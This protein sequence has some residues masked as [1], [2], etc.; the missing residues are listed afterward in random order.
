MFEDT[1][2]IVED[3]R[4]KVDNI[5][6][7]NYEEIA[8]EN[9]DSVL[10]EV[11]QS[12][13]VDF[14]TKAAIATRE[15][16]YPP[17]LNRLIEN[18]SNPDHVVVENGKVIKFFD[19]DVAG[20][21][22]DFYSGVEET[23]GHTGT[24]QAP[25]IWRYGIY[26]PSSFWRGKT[27]SRIYKNLPSYDD[28]ISERLDAWGDKAPFWYLIEHGNAGGGREFPSIRPT[29]FLKNLARAVQKVSV[30][31]W[32]VINQLVNDFVDFESD[33][34]NVGEQKRGTT[35]A[36]ERVEIPSIGVK[37]TKLRSSKG[38]TFYNLNGERS[39]T[40]AEVM[41]RIRAL[42]GN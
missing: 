9:V 19:E 8:Q 21:A 18:L 42:T 27:G 13:L 6:S 20:T 37:L 28:V 16:A 17:L 36:V 14:G 35:I 29:N 10:R 39:L 32:D 25:A 33:I 3:I 12:M 34:I 1:L 31:T 2:K 30:G 15:Y 26:T 38:N 24:D 41:Y 5:L 23:G 11:V 40:A 7:V 22:Q 4:S